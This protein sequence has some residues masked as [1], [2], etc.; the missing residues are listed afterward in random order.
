[1]I[2][3]CFEADVL[4]EQFSLNVPEYRTRFLAFVQHGRMVPLQHFADGDVLRRGESAPGTGGQRTFLV[5]AH[6]EV[7]P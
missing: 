5:R 3:P 2:D 7:E 4:I 1:M 6:L